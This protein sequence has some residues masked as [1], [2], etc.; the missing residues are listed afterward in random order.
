M[1][2]QIAMGRQNDTQKP[3]WNDSRQRNANN[4]LRLWLFSREIYAICSI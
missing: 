2:K 3:P 4:L 1:D